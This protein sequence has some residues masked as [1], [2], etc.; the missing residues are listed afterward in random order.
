MSMIEI[1][2]VRSGDA[3]QIGRPT[4]AA[5]TSGIGEFSQLLNTR[6]EQAVRPAQT[7]APLA[8]RHAAVPKKT[9]EERLFDSLASFKVRTATVA[10]H[11]DHGWRERLFAQLDNL[12][13][14]ESWETDDLPPSLASFSTFLRMLI[15]LKPQ[16]RPGLGATA[17]G[18][19]IATWTAGSDRLTI[20][21]LPNDIARWHL[22][23]IIQDD[24]ERAAAETPLVRLSTVLQPYDPLRWFA[25]AD[26]IR[27]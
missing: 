8:M 3:L 10:M 15:L 19:L 4:I 11:L 16:R 21:C 9:L 17:D 27:P 2:R 22:S 6:I 23:V 12:M 13:A 24:R 5:L 25:D 26:R 18:H 20:E 1:P 7:I 14:L